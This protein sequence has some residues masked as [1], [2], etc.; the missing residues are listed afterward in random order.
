MGKDVAS[1]FPAAADIF[2]KADEVVGFKLSELCFEG[3]Q[4]KLNS[5]TY[6]QPA[7]FTISAAIL[8]VL[9]T[10]A[11]DNFKPALVTAGLSLGEYTAL[12]AAKAISFEDGLRLVQKRGEAMQ[13][14]AESSDG[15]MVSVLKLDDDKL[16]ELIEEASQGKLLKAANFNCPGQIV[17][18][19]DA[20]ACQRA[21]KLAEEKYGAMKAVPLAVAGAFH[22]EYMKPA[23]DALKSALENTEITVPKDVSVIANVSA[24][25]Y[26]DASQIRAGLREQ[27][28][29]PVLW[30]KCMERLI[31]EGVENFYEIGPGRVLTGLMKK[32][33]RKKKVINLSTAETVKKLI[34]G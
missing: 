12:Y 29:S 33:D 4:D 11:G 30:Q 17:L 13:K 22:T 6:S 10:E 18:S 25:Y 1:E 9:K 32:I 3:P 8:E 20:Q 7:I 2:K 23:S 34:A 16:D 5:T 14:A 31:G 15:S 24:D 21:A 26:K 27:L 28:T 19:G